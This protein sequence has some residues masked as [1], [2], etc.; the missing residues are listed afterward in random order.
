[1]TG[2]HLQQ[3]QG[4]ALALLLQLLD[5]LPQRPAPLAQVALA[6]PQATE[7]GSLLFLQPPQLQ[8]LLLGQEAAVLLK[9]QPEALSLCFHLLLGMKM[10]VLG[11]CARV[12]KPHAH[13]QC[14]VS[15]LPTVAANCLLRP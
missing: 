9:L 10:S 11:R 14:L 15:L 13:C 8:L 3:T 6:V 2:P 4:R 5:Q 7:R 1:M 12:T